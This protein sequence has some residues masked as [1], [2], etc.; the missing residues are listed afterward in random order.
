MK[1]KISILAAVVVSGLLFGAGCV[2]HRVVY[3]REPAVAAG[4][5][6]IVTA[7]PPPPQVEVVGMAPGPEFVWV[8]GCWEWHGHWVWAGGRWAVGPHP[9]AHWIPG[10]WARRGH[11]HV[12]IHGYW[13]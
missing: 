8:P 3:V 6:V 13:R 5:E 1:T 10:R 2:Q 12:W 9:H 11:G 4:G 7:T